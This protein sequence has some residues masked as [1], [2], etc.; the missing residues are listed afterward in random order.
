MSYRTDTQLL[1]KPHEDYIHRLSEA[2]AAK[3][4]AKKWYRRFVNSEGKTQR[5]KQIHS[6]IT[7]ILGPALCAQLSKEAYELIAQGLQ[8]DCESGRKPYSKRRKSKKTLDNAAA[9]QV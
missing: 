1:L 7:Q 6:Y 5:D 9:P 3:Q 4:S 2:D 8:H